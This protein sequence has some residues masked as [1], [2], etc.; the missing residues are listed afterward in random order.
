MQ[1]DLTHLYKTKT[2]NFGKFQVVVQEISHGRYIQAQDDMLAKLD[3]D[4]EDIA[5]SV[6]KSMVQAVKSGA[7]SVNDMSDIR[8]VAGIQSWTITAKNSDETL[9]VTID[10]YR[11]LPH[12]ITEQIEKEIEG[13]NPTLK[14]D[15]Q[16]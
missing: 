13:L 4:G 10:I 11:M 12:A 15:F 16:A 2:L 9:P 1:L 8:T 7:M 3:L 14:D 5:S 6:N